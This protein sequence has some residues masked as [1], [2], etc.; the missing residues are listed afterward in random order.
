MRGRLEIVT[1]EKV[2]CFCYCEAVMFLQFPRLRVSA[3]PRHCGCGLVHTGET[4]RSPFDELRACPERI[5]GAGCLRLGWSPVPV[6][7]CPGIRA[8]FS[9]A[10]A[11]VAMLIGCR[12]VAQNTSQQITLRE[13]GDEAWPVL[14]PTAVSLQKLTDHMAALTAPDMRGRDVLDSARRTDESGEATAAVGLPPAVKYI[15]DVFT[16]AELLPLGAIRDNAPAAKGGCVQSFDIALRALEPRTRLE[17]AVAAVKE[18]GKF[19][20]ELG[21]DFIPLQFT[22]DGAVSAPLF[23]AGYGVSA[24][25]LYYDD[26]RGHD[27]RG[28]IVIVLEG[29]PGCSLQPQDSGS[30]SEKGLSLWKNEL[31]SSFIYKA[32]NAKRRG[33]VAV[34]L[35]LR[36]GGAE[37]LRALGAW[38]SLL[39]ERQE[40]KLAGDEAARF[41]HTRESLALPLQAFAGRLAEEF[42]GSKPELFCW[43]SALGIE[44]EAG[45]LL[46]LAM[47]QEAADRILARAGRSVEA[48]ASQI[49]TGQKAASFELAGMS[50]VVECE[51]STRHWTGYDIAGVVAPNP[52]IKD[53][54]WVI[55]GAHHDHLGTRADGGVFCGANDNA[56]GVAALLELACGFSHLAGKLRRGVIFCAF[57]AEERGLRGSL[58]FV[59]N[60]LVPA[61]RVVAML[62]LDMIGRETRPQGQAAPE[63]AAQGKGA[64][65]KDAAVIYVIG[66]LRNPELAEVVSRSL[67]LEGFEVKSNIEFAFLRGGDHWPFHCAGIP[68]VQVT[69]SRFSEMHTVEDT[70][71]KISIQ[72]IERAARAIRSALLELADRVKMFPAPKHIVTEYPK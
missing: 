4:A 8:L 1:L 58:H 30:A 21:T 5:E 68:S 56:S 40:K 14:D 55:V 28:K 35:V 63:G 42:E 43:P 45:S 41:N 33:A 11:V 16:A 6:S 49:E 22:A 53:P 24:S 37:R 59:R 26:Y 71:D 18:S 61:E 20:P 51:T 70:L 10:L 19:A 32:A 48:A 27:V 47:T 69:T 72:T 3:S 25:E 9:V 64:P 31:H 39:P 66:A 2:F 52:K 54:E 60:L 23:F 7:L 62:N 34:L 57:D 36:S 50:A 15:A 44:R 29:L 38:P 13:G 46:V 67:G 17:I 65:E 12:S